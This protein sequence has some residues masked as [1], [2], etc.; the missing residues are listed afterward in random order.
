M[1][2]A[3]VRYAA[4]LSVGSRF[5]RR[6]SGR[7]W[8]CLLAMSSEQEQ[9][10]AGIAALEAQRA[11][12]GDAVV[13]ASL[14]GLRARLAALTPAAIES[15]AA[16]FEPEPAQALR[17]VTILFL[18]VV[19]STSL[20]QRLDP[21]EILV[22]MDGALARGASLVAAHQGKVLQYAGDSLLAVFGADEARE[23][24]AERAVRCGL[25]LLELG[26]ALGAEVH[27]AHGHAGFDVRIGIHTGPVLLGGGVDAESTIRGIAVNIAARMEQT[28]PAGALRISHDT[29][30][31]VRGLFD[32]QAQE[33]LAVKG[34]DAPV[35]SV[36][37]QRARPR[38][39][40]LATRGI[41]GVA[42]RMV[43]R[44]AELAALQAAFER[45]FAEPRLATVTV[46]AEAGVGKSRLLHEFE[47]WCRAQPRAVQTFRGRA[48]QQTM[49]QPFGLLRDI[50][51][52][53]A[54]IA[55]DDTLEAARAK[56]ER[57]TASL[58]AREGERTAVG[59]AHLLGHLIGIDFSASPHLRGILDDPRQ[60]RSRAF[61]AAAQIL[62]RSSESRGGE[63]VLLLLE[64]LH[65]ADDGTLAFLRH[66]IEADHDVPLL[67]LA[68]ARPS[69]YERYPA[70]GSGDGD[71]GAHRRI[72][73]QPLDAGASHL[74]A[75][76]LLQ[77]LDALP[78]ALH[79][80][81][82][83]RSEGNPFYMEELVKMLIDQGAIDTTTGER[84]RVHAD[85][86]LP[87]QIPPTLTGVLQARLDRLPRPERVALQEASVIGQV[88][89]DQ[90]LAAL[91]PEAPQALP[92]LVER[93]LTLPRLEAGL[94]D[95]R[96]YGFAHQILH[97]VT[98]GTLLKRARRVLHARAAAWLAGLA[99]AR[100][101]DFLAT[102]AEHYELAGD[103]AQA[104]AYFTRAAEHAKSRNAH[105]AALGFAARALALLDRRTHDE[106]GATTGRESLELRWQLL[107]VRESALNLQGKRAEQREALD[108]LQALADALQDDA[109]RAFIAR[110]RSHVAMRTADY[111]TQEAEARA[112]MRLAE[113]AGDAECKLHAQRL[114]ADALGA[115]GQHAEGEAIARA[116][117]AEARA[118]GLRRAEGVFLNTLSF[119]A[120]EQDDQVSGLA[121]DL[122]D[123]PIWRE[124]GDPQGESVALGNVGGD[125]LWFG[126]LVQA[127]RYLTQALELARSIGARFMQLGPLGDLS[128]VALREGD[129][130]QAFALAHEALGIA[131]EIQAADFEA[132][133][134]YRVGDAELAL[135]H[136]A[137]A[138][139]AYQRAEAMGREIR[140]GVELDARAGRARVALAMGDMASAVALVE[141]L[142]P[143]SDGAMDG[144]N[145]RLVLFSC[146]R[147][148]AA[149]GD[150]RAVQVLEGAY[151]ALRHR[152]ATISDSALRESFLGCIVENAEIAAAWRKVRQAGSGSGASGDSSVS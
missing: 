46:V 11:L 86:L 144:A 91:D 99:G 90:A 114:L 147:V 14:A 131:V 65:W 83:E 31:Q 142:L 115:Q 18:D 78:E 75:A 8:L 104:C 56:I 117:L 42:T 80:L 35:Q 134:L 66:L 5:D 77:R 38:S 135:G 70:W 64:D 116:G 51:A 12:L 21:E 71:D 111:R 84:W 73:L 143:A 132:K 123:L 120:S 59:H 105:D 138:A 141:P 130:E 152:A 58:F 33:P 3:A 7:A 127:R 16:A 74:L 76:E 50:V 28:A 133:L 1:H 45:L 29:Y 136:Y 92:A 43:G 72:D 79:A 23:D 6:R 109:R 106:S 36:L 19:G 48:T 113:R 124:L 40:R 10:R 102:T 119:I 96:E 27:A 55:D 110:K 22:V 126:E 25:A 20:A 32:V 108:A 85:K 41:E 61:H 122:E 2:A 101:N 89:W 34:V 67:V 63:P 118:L 39:F 112:A 146:Y 148:L 57:G 97:H 54:Q 44:D 93:G 140:L 87:T 13:E 9:L 37:V 121:L 88:F 98:Y 53:R 26:R 24:D 125:W 17:Q 47:A 94:D 107:S 15:A 137:Q 81:V 129:A 149:A 49:G 95:V 30:A 52:R 68:L 139:A 62:R 103:A 4:P 128:E 145:A 100:A 60:I 151:E 150:S 69:L 82:A